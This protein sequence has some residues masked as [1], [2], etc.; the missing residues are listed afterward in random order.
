MTMNVACSFICRFAVV[1]G[2]GLAV[3]AWAL[4][5]PLLMVTTDNGTLRIQKSWT[6]DAAASAMGAK[7]VGTDDARVVFAEGAEIDMDNLSAWQQRGVSVRILSAKAIEGLPS[8]SA[9]LAAVHAVCTR[10][11][12]GKELYLLIPPRGMVLNFR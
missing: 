8:V 3:Q 11:D 1:V 7:L 2:A 9:A 6:L 4:D 5:Y 10:S 12:D